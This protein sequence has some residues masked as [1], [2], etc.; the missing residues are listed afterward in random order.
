[1][2]EVIRLLKIEAA[3]WKDANG[4]DAPGGYKDGDGLA[5]GRA[6][7]SLRGV[8]EAALRRAILESDTFLQVADEIAA[9]DLETNEGRS[10]A[11]ESALLSGLSIFQR[12]FANPSCLATKHAVFASLTLC[13]SEL[14]AYFGGAQ[15]VEPGSD[16]VPELRENWLFDATQ[17]DLLFKGRI[18]EIGWFGPLGALGLMNLD[19]SEPFLGCPP[20]Q[21]YIVE[22]VL[23]QIIPFIK[24]TMIA[25]GWAA[26]A[27]GGYTLVAL[28]QKQ[29]SHLKWIRKQGELEIGTLLPHAQ[30]TFVEALRECDASHVRMLA[31]PEPAEAKLSWHLA[32]DGPYDKELKTKVTGALP[33][34]QLRRAFPGLLPPSAPR[35][36]AGVCL[37]ETAAPATDGGGKKRGKGADKGGGGGGSASGGG[38]G[39]GSGDG[40]AKAP[41]SLKAVVTWIDEYHMRLGDK[42]YDTG[43]IADFYSLDKDHCFPV[44]LSTKKANHALSLCAHWGEP[45][46]TSLASEKHA[47]PKNFDFAYVCRHLA[48]PAPKLTDKD[49]GHKKKKAKITK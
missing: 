17:C 28:F 15:A 36:L 48:K 45:G 30:K 46:H 38:G 47:T 34:I 33:I 10:S 18:S 3:E 7:V 21:L 31:H 16:A 19:A 1:M 26:E 22:S 44:L 13:L 40:A 5:L 23:E 11:L 2:V 49:E 37:S 35:S 43:A 39:G 32:F 24:A 6:G 14:P 42:I 12:F 27:T 20:D 29:L 25:A 4:A 9:L 41:G 8:T